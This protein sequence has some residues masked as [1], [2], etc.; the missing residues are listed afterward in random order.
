MEVS[1]VLAPEVRKAP[2]GLAVK[3]ASFSTKWVRQRDQFL[4]SLAKMLKFIDGSPLASLA[5]LAFVA[6][7]AVVGLVLF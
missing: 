3:I 5:S 4:P 7:F 6:D 2:T 1:R